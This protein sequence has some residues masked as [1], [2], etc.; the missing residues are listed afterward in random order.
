MM[1]LFAAEMDEH[2]SRVGDR[3]V[4][5]ST[6]PDLRCH[7]SLVMTGYVQVA[8]PGSIDCFGSYSLCGETCSSDCLYSC[9]GSQ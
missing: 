4:T 6:T 9:S 5:P 1:K 2:D 8:A 7:D 3:V